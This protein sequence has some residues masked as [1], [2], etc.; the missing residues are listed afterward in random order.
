MKMNNEIYI[1]DIPGRLRI[2]TEAIKKNARAAA[3]VQE[4]LQATPGVISTSVNPLTGSVTVTYDSK[5]INSPV[6]LELL[7]TH[8]YIDAEGKGCT[9]PTLPAQPPLARTLL[10][11]MAVPRLGKMILGW[12][13]ERALAAAVGAL[14]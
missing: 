3:A 8:N 13:I 6:I 2:R 7:R 11:E 5:H 14:L 12:T 4:L 9:R 10:M 1:H